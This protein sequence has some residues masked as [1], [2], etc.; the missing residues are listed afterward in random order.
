MARDKRNF[1]VL[2]KALAALKK[3]VEENL[4]QSS[5]QR[6]GRL[7]KAFPCNKH[8]GSVPIV[9]AEPKN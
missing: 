7:K 5:G 3:T 2:T 9:G 6:L 8:I 4:L 1:Q